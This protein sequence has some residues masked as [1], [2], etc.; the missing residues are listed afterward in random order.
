MSTLLTLRL[1]FRRRE[2]SPPPPNGFIWIYF[3]DNRPK[4]DEAYLG[5]VTRDGAAWN[6]FRAQT[7]GSHFLLLWCDNQITTLSKSRP[8]NF[9]L[10]LLKWPQRGENCVA[11][12]GNVA[13]GS[14]ESEKDQKINGT[15]EAS[16]Y[17]YLRVFK[18]FILL[19]V[20]ATFYVIYFWVSCV[21]WSNFQKDKRDNTFWKILK[22]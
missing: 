3:Q 21:E 8:W 17:F 10:S 7:G 14:Q 5:L 20:T 1:K 15:T 18:V 19:S 9:L 16:L 12:Q 2:R 6:T 11:L 4:N 13:S 22:F